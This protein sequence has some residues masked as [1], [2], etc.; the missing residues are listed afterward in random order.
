MEVGKDW[1]D[2]VKESATEENFHEVDMRFFF[3]I[4]HGVG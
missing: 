3:E 4:Q 1:M 2:M